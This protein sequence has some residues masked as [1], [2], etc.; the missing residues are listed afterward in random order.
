MNPLMP[1]DP[2]LNP[3]MPNE[4]QMVFIFNHYPEYSTNPVDLIIWL[5]QT[6]QYNEE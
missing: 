5:Y 4:D 2:L 3:L 6:A 1:A